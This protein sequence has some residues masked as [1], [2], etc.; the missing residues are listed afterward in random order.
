MLFQS[1]LTVWPSLIQFSQWSRP[2]AVYQWGIP[3]FHHFGDDAANLA[4]YGPI[5]IL[6]SRAGRKK[7]QRTRVVDSCSIIVLGR[8]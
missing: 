3:L 7:I 5:I 6:S 1:F 4:P 2:L 8:V